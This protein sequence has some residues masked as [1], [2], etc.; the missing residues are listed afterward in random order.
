[1]SLYDNRY[2]HL[3]KTFL[4]ILGQWPFQSRL[5]GN[6]F[7]AITL[8]FTC[9]LTAIELWGLIAGISD[10]NIFMQNAAPLLVN[11]LV[12]VKLFNSIYN[13][14]K[15]KALLENIEQTWKAINIG[16][17]SDILRNYAEQSRSLTIKYAFFLY[18]GWI[19]Y[20][21]MP[22]FI[23]GIY[24]FLPTNETYEI[25]YIFR[26]EHVIDVDKHLHILML[27]AV[28]SVFF[29]VSIPVAVDG[30]FILYIQH[31][32]ALIEIIRYN[33]KRIQSSKIVILEPD[34]A[35]DEAYHVLIRCIK[36]Y[37]RVLQLI[38]R[39]FIIYLRNMQFLLLGNI[40]ISLSFSAAEALMMKNQF[41]ELLRMVGSNVAQLTHVFSLSLLC[42]K[43]TDYSS[44]LQ[45]AVYNCN[46][47][48]ISLRSRQLLRFTLMRTLKPCQIKAGKLHVMSLQNFGSILRISVSYFTMLTSVQ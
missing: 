22:F 18:F 19:F 33:L 48:E 29:I 32:L 3:N 6:A 34:I 40:M 24:L 17:E 45:E 28:V 10:I 25:K 9:S 42:Q 35:D 39:S 41:D 46:W 8:F 4:S 5:E 16:P 30:I 2:Y 1:M 37:N 15:M 26:V 14:Y 12:F 27:H 36:S 38:F 44:G 20:S 31:T 11:S 7:L 23:K 47:Y 21:M 43:L 13:K